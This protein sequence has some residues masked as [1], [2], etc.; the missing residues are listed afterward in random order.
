MGT[1][2][3]LSKGT[4]S[5]GVPALTCAQRELWGVCITPHGGPPQ[6]QEVLSYGPSPA[7]VSS[8]TSWPL[9]FVLGSKEGLRSPGAIL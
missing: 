1:G 2:R 9:F 8:G 3:K 4:L 7:P 6:Y 5:D